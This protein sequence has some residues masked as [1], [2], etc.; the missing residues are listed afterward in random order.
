M[1]SHMKEIVER[2]VAASPP[3]IALRAIERSLSANNNTIEL[4]VPLRAFGLPTELGLEREA[5]VT[6]SAGHRN[7]LML[8]RRYERLA[9]EWK[10]KGGGPYPTFKGRI[11]IRPLSGGTELELRGRYEPPFGPAGAAFDKVVGGK[12]ASATALALLA[13]LKGE[14]ERE[15]AG[16]KEAIETAP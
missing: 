5:I 7:K 1:G 13:Q 14:L 9:I 4:I 8:G 3:S 6:F 11:T 16:F 2:I 12:V 10:P 15:Y